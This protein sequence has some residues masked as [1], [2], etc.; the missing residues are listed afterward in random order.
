MGNMKNLLKNVS[1][2]M[3]DLKR[4]N[5]ENQ[6]NNIGL[7]RPPFRRPYQNQPPPNP[8]ETLTSKDIY[9]N[10]KAINIGSQTI[11]GDTRD[12]PKETKYYEPHGEEQD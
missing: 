10:F 6:E 4:T 3:V 8:N 7:E 1:N 2:D 5:T 9:S 12:N 11:P